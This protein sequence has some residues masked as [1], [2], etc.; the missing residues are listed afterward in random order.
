MESSKI[1]QTLEWSQKKKFDEG[2][3]KTVEWYLE[4]KEW[5]MNLDQNIL[6]STPWK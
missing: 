6:D 2:I 1:R 3:E 4:N 5:W